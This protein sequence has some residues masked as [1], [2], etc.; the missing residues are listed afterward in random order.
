MKK[1]YRLLST[2]TLILA[3]STAS[4]YGQDACHQENETCSSA[5]MQSQQTAHWS[6]YVPIVLLVGAAVLFGIADGKHKYHN[7]RSDS[8]D[9]LGSIADS[10]RRGS[11]SYHTYSRMKKLPRQS[12]GSHG[13]H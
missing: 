6:V 12:Y 7:E 4:I 10:K 3:F 8:Q 9:A 13:H 2:L 5:Y 11:Q 1:L